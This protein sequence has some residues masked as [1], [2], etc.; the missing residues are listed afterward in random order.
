MYINSPSW[1]VRYVDMVIV[2]V[3]VGH[4]RAGVNHA[5]IIQINPAVDNS[6]CSGFRSIC[7]DPPRADCALGRRVYR[8]DS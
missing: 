4:S 6:K 1:C 7:I 3:I 2:I 5:L 8:T